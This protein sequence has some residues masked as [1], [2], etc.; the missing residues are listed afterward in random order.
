M[1]SIFAQI[2]TTHKFEPMHPIGVAMCVAGGVYS[3]L[4]A[5]KNWEWFF[6]WPPAPTIVR[7]LTRKGA[8]F[9]YVGLGIFVIAGGILAGL[10][11]I[12]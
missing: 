5:L 2:T 12:Q 7:V 11:L 3:I 1:T 10:G 6:A 4:G 8:R 9:F